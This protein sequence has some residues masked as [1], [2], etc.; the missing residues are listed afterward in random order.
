M[1]NFAKIGGD[2]DV[3][4]VSAQLRLHPELW[5]EHRWRTDIS[6]WPFS[7]TSDIWLRY[8]AIEELKEAKDFGVEHRAVFYP[9]WHSLVAVHDIV[10]SLM[11]V[12]KAVELGGILITRI[13][14][15]G[16]VKPHHDRGSWHAEFF[17]RKCYVII[18]ANEHCVNRFEDEEVVMKTGEVYLFNNLVTHSVT[19]G[20][21]SERITL[22]VCMRVEP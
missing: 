3:R 1:M 7:G 10:F 6:G 12:V 21:D 9:A 17:N 13:P 14:A 20:G 15:G 18:K 19:N 4:S 16:S 8:R 22:I 11:R 5:D 2:I